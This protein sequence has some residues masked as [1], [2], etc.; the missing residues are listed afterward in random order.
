MAG[1]LGDVVSA[2]CEWLGNTFR[3]RRR[4]V[5]GVVPIFNP[6][7]VLAAFPSGGRGECAALTYLSERQNSRGGRPRADNEPYIAAAVAMMTNGDT[8]AE[9]RAYLRKKIEREH[10]IGTSAASKRISGVIMPM[11]RE[12]TGKNLG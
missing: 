12:R 1:P 10:Q 3:R 11:A 8:E 9:V 6:A 7:E 4:V 2:T 5:G